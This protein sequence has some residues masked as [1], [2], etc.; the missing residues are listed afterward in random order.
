MQDIQYKYLAH[1][2]YDGD[3]DWLW[4][5]SRELLARMIELQNKNSNNQTYWTGIYKIPANKIEDIRYHS[6]GQLKEER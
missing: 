3:S 5:D 4:A 1:F 6:N 2:V